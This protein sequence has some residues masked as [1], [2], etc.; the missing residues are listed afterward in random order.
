MRIALEHRK[1]SSGDRS[2][3]AEQHRDASRARYLVDAQRL[4][5]LRAMDRPELARTRL[6]GDGRDVVRAHPAR[7]YA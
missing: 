3:A 4:P 6:R 2:E 5:R 7:S 1:P